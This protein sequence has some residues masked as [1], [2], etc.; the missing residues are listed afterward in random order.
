MSIPP[1]TDP[2]AQALRDE[3]VAVADRTF[4]RH[5]FKSVSMDDLA[6]AMGR[7]KKTLYQAV[8]SKEEL[9]DLVLDADMCRDDE[10]VSRIAREA[11]DAV[12]EMLRI[13]RYFAEQ[14]L[15]TDPAG[16]YDLHKYYRPS[17]ERLD[18]HHNVEMIGHV[19]AN[20]RRGQAEGLYRDDM[21]RELVALLFVSAPKVMLNPERL[22]MRARDWDATLR[23]F[24][25][26]HLLGVC[27]AAG[28]ERLAAYLR[29]PRDPD[30][31]SA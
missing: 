6:R 17:W 18:R 14:M 1:D 23:Q 11:A 22:D 19:R 30:T 3:L 16:L 21:D 27:S 24:L 28:R 13:G 12:D 8:A 7:S 20:L 25:H 4:R 2:A 26:Y 5:G 31:P 15:D 9:I 10:A 29:Q